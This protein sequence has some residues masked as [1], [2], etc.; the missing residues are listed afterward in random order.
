MSETARSLQETQN[1][2]PT[3]VP[4][5]GSMDSSIG[6][7]AS[8]TPT[9][10][11]APLIA[12]TV[13]GAATFSSTSDS[14]PSN[15]VVSATLTGSSLSSI[16]GLVKAHD[17]SQDSVRAKFSSPPG[18][19]VAAPSFSY[20]V[21]PRTNLTSGNPQLSSSSSVNAVAMETT[22][23]SST[24]VNS[25]SVQ[26]SQSMPL[27]TST[28]LVINANACAASMLIPAAPSFTAHAEMPNVR[29]IPGLTGNSSSITASIG[30]TIKPTPTNSSNSSP[31][32]IIPV[33]AAQPPTSTSV[34][35]PFP[36]LQNV[37][38]QTNSHYSSQPAM[39]PSPQASWSHPPQAG[40]M[41]HVSFS[42]YPGFFPSPF[43]LPV[44][45]IAS[46]VPLPFI[47]PPGVSLMVSQV[48]PTAVTA[49]SLQPGS[50]MVAESSSF[51][52]MVIPFDQL[53]QFL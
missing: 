40:P 14:V 25:Q 50:S 11:A 43:S 12:S 51:V 18:F 35:V 7:P 42:P 17:T 4:N 37:Q 23:D 20:G 49:G 9:S 22:S 31:R 48:E 21:I 53:K 32:P 1:P 47:Q 33:S 2:V 19:V 27:G 52:G 30:A 26:T 28:G 16:G 34:P 29:G 3:S 15:V 44:Q 10:A 8:G 38:Q 46:A 6:G 36:V 24:L 41:Q 45:G 39:A 13:Q 5:S